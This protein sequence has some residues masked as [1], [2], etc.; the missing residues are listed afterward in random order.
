M[1]TT[2]EPS[3]VA[4]AH[5]QEQSPRHEWREYVCREV[6]KLP[7]PVRGLLF[8]LYDW[9]DYRGD[10]FRTNEQ[11][12]DELCV[13][14]RTV[15]SY[16]SVAKERGLLDVVMTDRGRVFRATIPVAE[17]DSN[18]VQ[19]PQSGRNVASGAEAS[20]HQSR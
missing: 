8:Q 16:L 6:K 9:M 4:P 20:F 5:K 12:A 17:T 13:T 7:A 10:C 15:R 11:L 19:F 3:A 2:H 14:D 18:V 1:S